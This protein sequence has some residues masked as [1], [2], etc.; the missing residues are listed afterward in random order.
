M[1]C[2][3]WHANLGVSL[4]SVSDFSRPGNASYNKKWLLFL[5]SNKRKLLGYI[6]LKSWSSGI[7]HR[8]LTGKDTNVQVHAV[9]LFRA[10]SVAL[11]LVALRPNFSIYTWGQGIES[12]VVSWPHLASIGKTV[13]DSYSPP[14]TPPERKRDH[15][16]IGVLTVLHDRIGLTVTL[17]IAYPVPRLLSYWQ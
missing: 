16:G 10:N 7:W 8:L 11:A 5:T 2:I 12:C 4:L 17:I 15:T 6:S 1:S 3:H 9:W 13:G 14:P